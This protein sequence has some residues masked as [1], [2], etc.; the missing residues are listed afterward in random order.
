VKAPG[1]LERKSV[2]EPMQTGASLLFSYNI[3]LLYHHRPPHIQEEEEEAKYKADFFFLS[4]IFLFVSLVR[5]KSGPA[6]SKM[7]I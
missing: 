1:I 4:S 5:E 6:R 7:T 2:H 3:N